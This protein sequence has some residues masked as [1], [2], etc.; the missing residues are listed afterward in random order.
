[1]GQEVR[2]SGTYRVVEATQMRKELRTKPDV[3]SGLLVDERSEGSRL[4]SY[5]PGNE[6]RYSLVLTALSTFRKARYVLGTEAAT[7]V[8]VSNY[9]RS[10]ILPEGETIHHH[11]IQEKMRCSVFDAVVLAELLGH[12]TDEK[13]TTVDSFI[14]EM[15]G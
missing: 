3:G 2:R 1:M 5:E 10:M 6:T 14:R 9:G 4:V 12:L 7:L 8:Y 11:V 13:C 15:A